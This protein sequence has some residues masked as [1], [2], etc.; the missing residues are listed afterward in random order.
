MLGLL[1]LLGSSVG[2]MSQASHEDF[3]PPEGKARQALETALT[4]WQNGEP[5]DRIEGADAKIVPMDSRWRAGQKLERFEII[6]ADP[7]DAGKTWFSVR[8]TMKPPRGQQES[9]Y[10]VIGQDPLWVY[11]EDE[12]KKLSGM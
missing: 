6:R 10:V 1:L 9:R 12:Y 8:L 11:S 3:I 2:C 7:A 4:A 5:L